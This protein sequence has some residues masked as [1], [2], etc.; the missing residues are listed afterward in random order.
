M[1]TI[2]YRLDGQWITYS[3][4]VRLDRRP[5]LR[6]EYRATD[7]DG[8]TSEV[9]TLKLDPGPPGRTPGGPGE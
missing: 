7:A 2:E 8:N 5:G 4:P 9:R 6:L 3:E 1:D